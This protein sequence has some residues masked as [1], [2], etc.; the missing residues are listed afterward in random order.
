MAAVKRVTLAALAVLAGMPVGA[1][2]LDCRFVQA[3]DDVGAGCTVSGMRFRADLTRANYVQTIGS[4]T[5][6]LWAG[7]P[8]NT[9]LLSVDADG[10]A[11]MTL[12]SLTQGIPDRLKVEVEAA[13]TYSG[14]CLE[15]NE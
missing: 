2:E 15:V 1:V 9:Q 13:V 14:Q 8:G 10:Q 11:R 4:L 5:T 12:H 3:C 6:A 7:P